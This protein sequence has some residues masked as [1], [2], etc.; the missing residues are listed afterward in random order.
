MSPPKPTVPGL[1]RAGTAPASAGGK[2]RL[3]VV[4]LCEEGS[5]RRRE[6]LPQFRNLPHDVDRTQSGLENHKQNHLVYD[7]T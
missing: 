5:G 2:P 1:Y 7:E 4:L 3:T 6:E